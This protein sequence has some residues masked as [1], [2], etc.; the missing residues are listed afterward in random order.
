[1]GV[2]MDKPWFLLRYHYGQANR[3]IANLER[4][5]VNCFSP[6]VKM[7]TSG[8]YKGRLIDGEHLFPPYVFVEFNPEEIQFSSVQYTPG[9]SGFVRFG[10]AL[11]QVPVKVMNML[12]TPGALKQFNDNMNIHH[13]IQCRDKCQRTMMFL[14]LMEN[15]MSGSSVPFHII[16]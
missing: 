3:A 5:G 16:N 15:I 13:I 14:S 8:K 4:L 12:L 2:K 10:Q 7:H 1:M 11:K 9:V 6:K